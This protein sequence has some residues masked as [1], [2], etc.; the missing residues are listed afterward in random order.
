MKVDD[1]IE[2]PPPDVLN[3]PRHLSQGAPDGT[4]PH[5]DSVDGYDFIN[6]RAQ[7]GNRRTPMAGQENYRRIRNPVFQ[8]LERRQQ[9]KNIAEPG[10]ADRQDF[11]GSIKG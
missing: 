4:I 11:H 2:L 1:E 8:S 6:E 5:C 3:E 7:L 10:E 9:K